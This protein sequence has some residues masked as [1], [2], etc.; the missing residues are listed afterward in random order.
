[1]IRAN[2]IDSDDVGSAIFTTTP[3]VVAEYPALAA[4]KLGWVDVPLI[5][6]HEMAVPH[7]LKKCIRILL[8]WNTTL[9]AKEIKHIYIRGAKNLRPD[10]SDLQKL[11]EIASDTENRLQNGKDEGA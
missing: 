8:H 5:C 3:D 7:G 10:I 2:Q 4:R 6:G 11:P 9:K 1:M